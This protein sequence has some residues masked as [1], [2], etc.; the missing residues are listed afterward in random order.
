MAG[1]VLLCN[2]RFTVLDK[3]RTLISLVAGVYVCA[4]TG[5]AGPTLVKDPYAI[6]MVPLLRDCAAPS[7]PPLP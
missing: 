4:E 3:G 1:C 7:L 2:S 6:P 5:R